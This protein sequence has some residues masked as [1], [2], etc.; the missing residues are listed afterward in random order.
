MLIYMRY[1][2]EDKVKKDIEA[3]EYQLTKDTNDKDK[4]IHMRAIEQLKELL[5][6][7]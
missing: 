5:R 3:L 2:S 6:E 7:E 4:N 1:N